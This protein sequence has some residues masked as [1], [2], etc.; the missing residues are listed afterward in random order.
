M[1]KV[2]QYA[3]PRSGSTLIMQVLRKIFSVEEVNYS[4]GFREVDG[5]LVVTYRDFRDV[6]VSHWR[7]RWGKLE[8]GKIVNNPSPLEIECELGTVRNNLGI[9]NK[10]KEHYGLDNKDVLWLRYEDFYND[11]DYIFEKIRKVFRN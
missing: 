2:Y 9:L 1:I 11:Y 10:Y 8:N 5:K 7:I 4:H 3:L 6:M